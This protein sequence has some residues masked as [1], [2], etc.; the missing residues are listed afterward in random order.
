LLKYIKKYE[1]KIKI[2]CQIVCKFS[3]ICNQY[4]KKPNWKTY[5]GHFI[6]ISEFQKYPDPDNYPYLITNWKLYSYSYPTKNYSYPKIFVTEYP[7]PL[8]SVYESG[9]GRIISNMFAPLGF[10]HLRLFPNGKKRKNYFIPSQNLTIN[11]ITL[12]ILSFL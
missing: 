5:N 9:Y 7:Y 11:K 3:W 6:R 10:S 12:Q 1:K 4:K 2:Y 8:L